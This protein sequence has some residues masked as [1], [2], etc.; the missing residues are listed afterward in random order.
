M[1]SYRS[2]A[3]ACYVGYIT[4]AAVNNLAPLL[5]AVF[6]T[7]YGLSYEYISILILL[8]FVTQLL[9][10]ALSVKL[11]R[12]F[13][14][15]TLVIAAHVLCAAGFVLM[16]T[17]PLFD[18]APFVGLSAAAVVY[19]AG[20][21]LIEVLVSPVVESLPEDGRS[22][23]SAMGLL[24][25][26]YCWGQAA[27]ILLSTGFI[28]AFGDTDWYLLPIMWAV[29]PAANA[30]L[31]AMVPFPDQAPPSEQPKVKGVLRRRGFF[32]IML[33]ML[34][35]GACEL[36]ISQWSSMFAQRGLLVDKAVGDILGPCFFAVLMGTGRVL[37]S[38]FADRISIYKLLIACGVLCAG[39]YFAV[40]MSRNAVL[41]LAACAVCGLSVAVMWPGTFSLAAAKYKDGGTGMFGVLALCGDLGCSAGPA[42]AG[43]ICDAAMSTGAAE[44][45]GMRYGF[46]MAIIFPV[47]LIISALWLSRS[48]RFY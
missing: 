20:G 2:T 18:G 30:I 46:G 12:I 47:V 31:F 8:N 1:F 3:K 6:H 5:F 10:D 22:K 37:Y 15:R 4:Q 14:A 11:C 42:L 24:H 36:T 28:A 25:S 41:S 23:A 7:R 9:I 19:A 27:V 44:A 39:C 33:L 40:S 45:Q 21:G 29:L 26:F 16:G 35:A 17:T 43:M 13:T 32:F 34:C 38:R 48:R